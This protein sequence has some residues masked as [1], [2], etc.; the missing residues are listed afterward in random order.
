[1]DNRLCHQLGPGAAVQPRRGATTPSALLLSLE[2]GDGPFSLTP[3]K[4]QATQNPFLVD[5]SCP[6]PPD[7]AV[8]PSQEYAWGPGVPVPLSLFE[9]WSLSCVCAA[10][11]HTHT[12]TRA[13]QHQ[14]P[15][16]AQAL[17]LIRGSFQ[18]PGCTPRGVTAR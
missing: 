15:P 13:R 11:T 7:A 14:T 18:G 6:R 10:C 8:P 4:G 9:L 3:W 1:M 2:L 16:T 5:S 17:I 12:H